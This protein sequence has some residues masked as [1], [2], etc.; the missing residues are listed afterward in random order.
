MDVRLRKPSKDHGAI[1][2]NDKG[3]ITRLS[4]DDKASCDLKQIGSQLANI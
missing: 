3:Y 1:I 2:L 4:P